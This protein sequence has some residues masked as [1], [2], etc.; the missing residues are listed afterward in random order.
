MNIV[1]CMD[2]LMWKVRGRGE[3]RHGIHYV[4]QVFGLAIRSRCGILPNYHCKALPTFH[5]PP[6]HRTAANTEGERT[7]SEKIV[8]H[9]RGG[10]S[11]CQGAGN[12]EEAAAEPPC[13]FC[14][15]NTDTH[16]PPPPRAH[17][18]DGGGAG[19]RLLC[20]SASV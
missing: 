3:V 17:G 4:Q 12:K 16:A 5:T 18:C 11:Q 9:F 14:S 10:T 8:L 13:P 1:V 2:L 7:A 6:P 15:R 20:P 19:C